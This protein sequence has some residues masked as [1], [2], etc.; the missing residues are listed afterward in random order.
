MF[1][2]G[3]CL[4]YFYSD[5]K[6]IVMF[7]LVPAW[8]KHYEEFWLTIRRRN[9]WFIKLRYAAVLM[10]LFFIIFPKYFLGITLGKNQQIAIIVVTIS[11]LL[12]NILFHYIR[13]SFR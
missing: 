10:L 7:N 12:Y 6:E 9:L 3:I 13:L 8:A 5:K 2:I 4:F 1:V 11:I